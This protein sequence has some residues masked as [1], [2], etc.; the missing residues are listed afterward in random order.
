MLVHGS[1][2][3][4]DLAARVLVDP[5]TRVAVEEPGYRGF[6]TALRTAGAELLPIPVDGEGMSVKVLDGEPHV[7]LACVTPS[8][9]FPTGVVMPEARRHVLLDWAAQ[10]GAYLLEDD[11]DSEFRFDGPPLPCLQGLDAAGRVI[12]AGTFSKM[13]FPALR[14]GFVVAPEELR[15]PLLAAKVM[16]DAGNAGIEQRAM[17]SFIQGGH[18]ERHLRRAR[19]RTARRRA[20]LLDTLRESLGDRVRVTGENA[21]LH[22]VLWLRAC[23][24][25]C[26]PSCRRNSCGE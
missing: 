23:C 16:T 20:V 5:G 2:Q 12:Y 15:P 13:M 11:Y 3:A 25:A 22:V 9:Q 17:S 7:R 18:F 8:H 19:T 1:Q 6:H 24:F 4:I 14:L 21:G 10:C 26:R